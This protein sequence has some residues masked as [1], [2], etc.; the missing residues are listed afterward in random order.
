MRGVLSGGGFMRKVDC[1]G[2][3]GCV[4]FEEAQRKANI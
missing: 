4:Q 3:E 2:P 1:I